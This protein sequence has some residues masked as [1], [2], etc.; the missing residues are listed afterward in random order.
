MHQRFLD[1]AGV[2]GGNTKCLNQVRWC[3]S[4]KL[5][6]IY[7]STRRH[8]TE[9]SAVETA[10]PGAPQISQLYFEN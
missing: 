10:P 2:A 9:D 4:A 8:I 7:Q 6:L 1:T 3:Y 5:V